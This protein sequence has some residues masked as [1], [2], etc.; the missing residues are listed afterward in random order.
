MPAPSTLDPRPILLPEDVYEMTLPVA[1]MDFQSRV[2]R[3]ARG[4][5]GPMPAVLVLTRTGDGE[6]DELSLRLAAA[7]I[8][9]VR[10]DSDRI[11]GEAFVWDPQ[12][13]VVTFDG[14]SFSPA[15]CWVRSFYRSAIECR[16]DVALDRYV[17]DQWSA[18]VP[19]LTLRAGTV[20]L[21]G[22][23]D[24]ARPD[25]LSQQAAAR[26]AGFRVP[27]SVVAT[28]LAAAAALVPGDG[29][30][31]VKTLGDH[32]VEHDPGR[33]AG[34]FPC[35]FSR[36]D[37][38]ALPLEPAPVIVEEFVAS[39]R[40]LRVQAVGRQLFAFE[41]EKAAPHTPWTDPASLHVD[42]VDLPARLRRPLLDL[43]AHW[44][45]DVA[46]FDVLESSEGPVFLEVNPTGDWLSFEARTGSS[47]VTDA[48]VE[49]LC[50]R[51][52]A[53]VNPTQGRVR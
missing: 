36:P 44:S 49:L 21:N 53:H 17:R 24:M 23:C 50:N 51:F 25:R 15:V 2:G 39:T 11:R 9:L 29:D 10:V 12:A 32:F 4:D 20:V 19:A 1:C 43:L 41:V 37:L 14:A 31:M 13:N 27:A 40:E 34:L 18:L 35:R 52:Y 46:A 48:V 3:P 8:P 22:E 6:V 38:A 47:P 7:G 33:L 45:L 16:G 5:S 42:E 28:D 26:A 30:L